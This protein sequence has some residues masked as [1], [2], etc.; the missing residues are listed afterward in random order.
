MERQRTT[1]LGSTMKLEFVRNSGG[2]PVVCGE[3]GYGLDAEG[4]AAHNVFLAQEPV[5]YRGYFVK[6]FS[7]A[8]SPHYNAERSVKKLLPYI[9][10]GYLI[11]LNGC[12]AAPGCAWFTTVGQAKTFIDVLIE[13]GGNPPCLP[14]GVSHEVRAEHER[15]YS[16]WGDRFWKAYRDRTGAP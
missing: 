13:M 11:T 2:L 16:G 5:E 7:H 14:Y 8:G 9:Y 15:L 4:E 12:N 10:T 3:D 1:R 6:P